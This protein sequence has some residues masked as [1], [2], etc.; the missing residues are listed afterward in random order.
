MPIQFDDKGNP[1]PY[2]TISI[3]ILGFVKI[4][5]SIPDVEVRER[6]FQQLEKYIDDFSESISPNSWIQWFGG[7]YITIKHNVVSQV[8]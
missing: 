8:I 7:S 6:L 3:D 2:E 1:Y 4:F 5:V